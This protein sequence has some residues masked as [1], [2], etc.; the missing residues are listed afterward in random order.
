MNSRV[1]RV[2]LFST[3]LCM[4]L[5]PLAFSLSSSVSA[6]SGGD[7]YLTWEDWQVYTDANG[8]PLYVPSYVDP[9]DDA[10]IAMWLP[11]SSCYDSHINSPASCTAAKGCVFPPSYIFMSV[12]C[13]PP[14]C[15]W[16]PIWNEA[17]AGPDPASSGLIGRANSII[18]NTGATYAT[19]TYY[20]PC[21]GRVRGA[22]QFFGNACN[23]GAAIIAEGGGCE[24]IYCGTGRHQDPITCR[25]VPD[26]PVSP[27]LIDILGNG[28]DLTDAHSGVDFDLNSDGTPEHLSWTEASSDDA[29]LVLDRNGNGTIDDGTELC[30]NFTPQTWSANPNGFLALGEFDKQVKGGNSDG[31]IDSSDSIFE[32]L[33]LWCDANHN[34]ISEAAEVHKLPEFGIRQISLNYRE[35]R[36]R[37]RYGNSFRYRAQVRD[38]RGAHVGRW[39]YDVFFVMEP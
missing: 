13:Y 25:C 27:I 4:T 37:D 39:A 30:G 9:N 21:W 17:S 6:E 24:F 7:G 34:G 29:F 11:P 12:R 20:K 3:V 28:F 15:T 18:L 35:S 10:A 2:I 23:S 26:N 31:V 14:L 8:N 22:P 32:H 36:R 33:R 1:L 16:S 19:G 38:D 5:L